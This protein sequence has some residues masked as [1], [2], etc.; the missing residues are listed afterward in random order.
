MLLNSSAEWS[1]ILN[2]YT[3]LVTEAKFVCICVKVKCKKVLNK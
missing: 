3:R 1:K 2:Y